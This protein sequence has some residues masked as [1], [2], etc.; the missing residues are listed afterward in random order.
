MQDM[1]EQT[2]SAR[3][4][5]IYEEWSAGK[6]LRVLAREFE[7]SVMEVERG[8]DRCL[9]PFTTQNQMRAYKRELQKLEDIGAKYHALAMANDT[10]TEF[11]HI[12]AR[13]NERRCAMSGWSSINVRLDPFAAQV[14]EQPSQHEKIRDAI[15]RLKYGPDWTPPSDWESFLARDRDDSGSALASPTAPSED[16]Q[17]RSDSE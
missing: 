12:Y 2:P 13:I 7:V 16:D 9:P 14:K 11:A 8:I 17:N 10:N 3:D 5:Q 4:E 1:V 15:F 6:T